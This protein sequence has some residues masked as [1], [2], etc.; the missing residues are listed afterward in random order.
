MNG[1]VFVLDSNFLLD[2]FNDSPRHVAFMRESAGK[3][4]YVSVITEMELL[5]FHALTKNEKIEIE[6]FFTTVRIIPLDDGIKN[7]AIAF[8]RATRRKLPD[9]IIA[10]SAINLGAVL[11]TNDEK[12]KKTKF[13]GLKTRAI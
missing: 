2:Y 5:S 11:I 12:L 4:F 7:A 6:A 3:V 1:D 10:A 13:P 8:R 9:S